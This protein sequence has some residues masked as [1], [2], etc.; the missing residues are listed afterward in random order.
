MGACLGGETMKAAHSGG[1]C[2]SAI[3]SSGGR[4][5]LHRDGPAQRVCRYLASSYHVSGLLS[6]GRLRQRGA[7]LP[8]SF[9]PCTLNGLQ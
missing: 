9:G 7:S 3:C 2:V 5:D 1:M 8:C 4:L 6:S